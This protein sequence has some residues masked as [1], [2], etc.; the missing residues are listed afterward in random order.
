MKEKIL[1]CMKTKAYRPMRLHELSEA[2]EVEPEQKKGFRELLMEMEKEGLVMVTR[3]E[4]YGIPE[5]MG[6]MTG[7][8]KGH[9]KGYGFVDPAN[10]ELPSAYIP[11]NSMRSAFHMDRVLVRIKETAGSN[12]K[13]EGEVTAVLERGIRELPGTFQKSKKFGFVV[14]DDPRFNSDIFIP[15]DKAKGV[16]NGYK[17]VCRITKWAENRRNPEGKIIEV[18]GKPED[19]E[20][21]MLAIIRKH[22]LQETFPKGVMKEAKNI[23]QM[24]PEKEIRRRKDLRHLNIVTIDGPDAKDLD[25]AI[26][27]EMLD[28]E[29]IRLGVHIADVVHYVRSGSKLDQEAWQRGT[30][31][32]L[33]D[34]VLPML[35][36]ELSNGICSLNPQ[37]DRLTMTVFM[38][39]D[40]SGT[41]VDHSIHETVINSKERLIYDDV[42]DLLEKEDP[43][44][45]ERY[46]A[47]T[48][49]LKN[50]EMLYRRLRHR[51]DERG[52]IDFHF[53]ESKVI[54]DER[55]NP[56]D[57]RLEERRTANR[58]IEEFML[59]CNETVAEHHYWMKQPFIYR[60]HEDPDEE[61]M[62]DFSKF[63]YHFG[64]QL[65]NAGKDMHPKELQKLLEE[66][67]G[68]KEAPVINTVMLRSLKKAKYTAHHGTHFG[69]AARY[70]SHFTSPIRRYPDLAIHRIIKEVLRDGVVADE[71]DSDAL[72]ARLEKTAAHA[73]EQE[74]NAEEAERE[75]VD[76]KKAV[77]M[78][79]HIGQEYGGL[80]SGI[81]SFGIFVELDNTV[82]GLIRLSDLDDDYYVYDQQQ[83]TL[84]GERTKKIFRIGDALQVRIEGVNLPQREIDFTLVSAAH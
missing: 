13:A 38:D 17:V 58:M 37:V 5:K 49:D 24:I 30:S 79:D 29:R 31:V 47:I 32:Y 54:L 18:L 34:R 45:Q 55:G 15:A 84:T 26:S 10:P 66:V 67:E 7:I 60:I 53:A 23:P 42:S 65:K 83:L 82:E 52:S 70:Y 50:M 68:K 36:Q 40:E 75:S 25:D 61:R 81:T 43:Q 22:G 12:Q 71:Q 73:S 72:T 14:P 64:Y 4:R 77:Y 69:L 11:A 56:V 62:L 16:P 57:I 8:L 46:R 78:K 41:V 35:P 1:N 76:L 6:Y 59:V 3:S 19:P 20:T 51:R 2:V 33:V 80:I 63:I 48:Q 74:R 39:I 21:D 44:L 27:V 9:W 28:G